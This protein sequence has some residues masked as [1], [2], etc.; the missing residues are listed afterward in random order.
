LGVLAL[1]VHGVRLNLLEFCGHLEME[2]SGVAYRPFTVVKE[3]F[4]SNKK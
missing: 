3:K 4:V 1:I 2:W